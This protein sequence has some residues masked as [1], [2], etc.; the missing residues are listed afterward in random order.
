[1]AHAYFD[2]NDPERGKK[3]FDDIAQRKYNRFSARFGTDGADEEISTKPPFEPDPPP[4]YLI[5]NDDELEE[6][7]DIDD[8]H[9]GEWNG[10]EPPGDEPSH[11]DK[12]KT[13]IYADRVL[14]R[15]ALRDLPDPEP[16]IDNVLDQGTTA[17]LYGRWGCA[18]TF[19]A[20]DWAAS[21]GTG[22]AWQG[23]PTQQRRALYVVGEAAFGF[24]GRTDAWEQGWHTTINDGELD[25]LPVAVNL[26]KPLEVANLAALIDWGGYSFIILDTLAR[27]MVGADENSAKDCGMVVDSLAKLL[28][29]TPQGRGVVLGVHHAGKDGQTLRGSSAFEGAAD[30]VY[31]ASRD[32]DGAVITL[33]REKRK[34][35]PEFDRHTLRLDVIEGTGSAVVGVDRSVENTVRGDK[36]FSTFGSTFKA[37]GASKSELRSA[38]DM[39]PGTF[40]RA[41]SDL[42]E[43]GRIV[44]T[45]TDKRPFYRLADE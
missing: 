32:R 23:R 3:I 44:N 38:S 12:Q 4:L 1:M 27:M 21:V 40:Y 13:P 25:T 18:K 8:H 43:S 36:L 35:G 2:A 20:L 26:T 16:L 22:R 9:A 45:G 33:D 7:P 41:L 37:T 31:F 14:T 6:P 42:L 39:S 24:K 17:L 29:S 15:S 34:D 5:D 10:Q 28:A 11:D 19:I 30:T